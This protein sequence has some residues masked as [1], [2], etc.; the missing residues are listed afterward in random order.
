ME[1]DSDFP[2]ICPPTVFRDRK[3]DPEDKVVGHF[4]SFYLSPR[5]AQSEFLCDLWTHFT[6]GQ[7]SDYGIT[8]LGESVT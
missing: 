1:K 4:H 7:I 5:T 6:G 2:E 8:G 3:F